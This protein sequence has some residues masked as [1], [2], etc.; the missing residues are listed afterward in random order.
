[1]KPIRCRW[2]NTNNPTYVEYHDNEWGIPVYD[3]RKLL[4]FLILE[5]FQAGL[6]WE[7]VLN[8]REHFRMAFSDY[9]PHLIIAYDETK[10]AELLQ[11][12]GIIRHRKKIEAAVNNTK[13]YLKIQKEWGSFAF[14]IWHFTEGKIVQETGRTRSFLSDRV[15]DDLK[16]R[17]MQFIGTT[18][19]Y[20]FLQAVG[21][22][23]SHDQE[24]FCNFKK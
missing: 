20:A 12:P 13:V 6:S 1:M 16:Q 15:S 18:T 19:V 14:Y 7:T 4:E 17:G 5:P 24:C 10:I 8:K 22:I 21:I 2:C 9:D 3:D 23:W 11:N